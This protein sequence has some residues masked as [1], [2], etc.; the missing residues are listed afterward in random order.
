MSEIVNADFH[1]NY[2]KAFPKNL[3]NMSKLVTAQFGRNPISG[4]IPSDWVNFGTQLAKINCNFCALSGHFP[5][6]FNNL[7]NL[8]EAYWCVASLLFILHG[9][10]DSYRIASS[11]LKVRE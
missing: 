2:I 11:R 1:L 8:E 10:A 6:M 3:P 4:Q 5:D 7:P 9:A